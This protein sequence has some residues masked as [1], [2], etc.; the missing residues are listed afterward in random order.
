MKI[1]DLVTLSAR[2]K[3]LVRASWIDRED[4]G[5][6]VKE[7]YWSNSTNSDFIVRWAKS[8]WASVRH[9]WNYER[10]VSR[11][12]LKYARLSTKAQVE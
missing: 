11:A 7:K 9:R 12:D 3:K 2:G 8:Q 5:V 1:G 6:I 10:Y 4:I